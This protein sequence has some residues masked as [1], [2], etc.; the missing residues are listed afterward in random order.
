MFVKIAGLAALTM[1]VSLVAGYETCLSPP[2]RSAPGRDV[3]FGELHH[4]QL[5]DIRT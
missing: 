4:D 2:T 5:D 3:S 1:T